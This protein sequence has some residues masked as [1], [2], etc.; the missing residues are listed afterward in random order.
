MH[1]NCPGLQEGKS[2][3]GRVTLHLK[4]DDVEEI[5]RQRSILVRLLEGKSMEVEG[6]KY[7]CRRGEAN[8]AKVTAI[9]KKRDVI[10]RTSRDEVGSPTLTVYGREENV[11]LALEDLQR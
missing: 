7:L 9:K 1:R 8:L 2:F 11:N 3:R 5:A 6:V 10:V 4:G